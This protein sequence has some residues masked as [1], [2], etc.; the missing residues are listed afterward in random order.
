MVL[1]AFGSGQVRWQGAVP[2]VV[3]LYIPVLNHLSDFV[4]FFLGNFIQIGP[5]QAQNLGKL[6]N[7]VSSFC[8][9]ANCPK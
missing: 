9:L 1:V 6:A 2:F 8:A 4:L 3:V 7:K 5:D